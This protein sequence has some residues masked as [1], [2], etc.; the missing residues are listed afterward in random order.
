MKTAVE[1]LVEQLEQNKFV[2][3]S[4]IHI[5]ELK[6]KDQIIEAMKIGVNCGL[7]NYRSGEDYYK[8]TYKKK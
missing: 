6:E 8:R 2:T 1:W 3:K 7:Y 4:Q 5:A